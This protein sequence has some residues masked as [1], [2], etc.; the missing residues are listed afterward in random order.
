MQ[1]LIFGVL[2]SFHVALGFLAGDH[3][4]PNK[5]NSTKFDDGSQNP[6]S[7]IYSSVDGGRTWN[8]FDNGVPKDA[9]VSSFLI[10]DDRIIAS[11]DYHGIYSIQDGE[12][13][14]KRLDDDLPDN[15]DINTISAIGNTLVI[16][17]LNHGVLISKNKG[18]N[19]SYPTI[20]ISN[21]HIRSFYKKGNVIFAGADNGIFQSVD[22]G[23]TWTHL[24]KGVQVN[25]FT[26]LK[27]KI[28]A[29]LMNGA[30]MSNDNGKSWKYVYKP[31]TLHD[32]STDG[33]SIYAMTLGDGLKKSSDDGLTWESVNNGLGTSNL[34]TFEL[35]GYGNKIFAAQWHGIYVSDNFG[36][37]WSLIKNGLPDSTAFTT[38]EP[39]KRG[40]ITGIGLRKK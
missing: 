3:S 30:V 23:N 25:G 28:Y 29:A 32:I 39:S 15:I 2:V 34:Y 12:N 26:E 40:L 21:T 7:V 22:N 8:P 1:K 37:S 9:T 20:Q 33:V 4:S 14:W 17:T 35:K 31:H 13:V 10:L 38:L 16:G 6:I 24:W 27:G 36:K 18:K 5:I 11:T 19:W